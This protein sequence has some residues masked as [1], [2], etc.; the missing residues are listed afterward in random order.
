MQC[1][2]DEERVKTVSK[3]IKEGKSEYEGYLLFVY[4]HEVCTTIV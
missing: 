3:F 1:K 4:N 2:V